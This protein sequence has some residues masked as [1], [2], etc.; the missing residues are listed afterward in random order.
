VGSGCADFRSAD[1]TDGIHPNQ[2]GS[3]KIAD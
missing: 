3:I 2:A 1:F